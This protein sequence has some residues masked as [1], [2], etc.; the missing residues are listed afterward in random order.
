MNQ[1]KPYAIGIDLGGTK[2]IAA[3][4]DEHGNIL[5]Q[6]N[7][8]TQTEEAAQAVIGR[9]GDL[10]QTVLDESGINL[11]RIRG[12]GIATAGIIDTQRQMVIFASNLNWS[13][14]P[15]GAILQERFGVAVQLINDA[16]AAAV[17]EW[18]FGSAR[19]T[20][21]LIY[22]TVSTGV[23]AGIISGGRLITGVGD[24]AG[25]FGHISL[26]PEGPLCVCGNRGCLEN[27]TS[28]LALASRAR[29]QLLQGATSSL[30]VENGNDLSRITAKEVGE[31]AVRGDLL[32]MT[33]MKEAGYYLG[34]GLT[35]LI[36]LFNPQVI[37]M[38]G[39][40]M[41]NGQL[42]LAEAKNVIRERSI[43]R[44]AN[45]ASI[46]LTT[47][48]AEAGVLGAAGMYYPSEREMV[49]V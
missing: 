41:K 30:L 11:S 40:V 3:I 43:S 44:M 6:A 2:I 13:D 25:E 17:A 38:G 45:Q 14:V 29:E 36:H 8:A 15:I 46:Q 49:E 7:A 18:A 28:G 24:S 32:S 34:V 12:I 31:A 33:L 35:N 10:V 4:V 5:R 16:N 1:D 26:D 20:K 19:G 42:L 9:I 48:G 22:V 47:I 39:G 37:V 27:Y 23:G 21:D